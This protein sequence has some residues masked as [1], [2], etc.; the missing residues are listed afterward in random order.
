[1]GWREVSFQPRRS[2]I[3][4][5][6]KC[7]YASVRTMGPFVN[8]VPRPAGHSLF[9][10]FIDEIQHRYH[11]VIAMWLEQ[12][13]LMIFHLSC[14]AWLLQIDFRV[15][16]FYIGATQVDHYIQCLIGARKSKIG[17]RDFYW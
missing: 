14:G 2:Q 9:G 16:K 10:D 15:V 7:H 4:C 11:V 12:E 3:L 5:Q 6:C 1:M 13:I 17:F 8:L